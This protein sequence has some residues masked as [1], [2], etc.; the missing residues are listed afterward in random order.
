MITLLRVALQIFRW[1]R[2]TPDR[3]S[4][5]LAAA[6]DGADDPSQGS[7]RRQHPEP[8]RRRDPR[9]TS[10]EVTLDRERWIALGLMVKGA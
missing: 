3:K 7:G 9:V 5:K 4:C 2:T 6:P 1:E 10:I 8:R